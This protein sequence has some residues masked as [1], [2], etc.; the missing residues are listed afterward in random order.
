MIK[1][2]II[3]DSIHE[4]SKD[5]ITTFV[6]TFPRIILAELNTH[7]A[8][9]RNSASSR[10]I[11]FSKMVEAAE[12]T[13]FIPLKWMKDHPGMQ[14]TEYFNDQDAQILNDIWLSGR[15]HAVASAKLLRKGIGGVKVT[16][17]MCNR[18]LEPYMYH[19]AI[20]TATE[21]EN[22]FALRANDAA[23]IHIQELANQMLWAINE[24]QP[25]ILRPGDWHIPF[26]DLI[27]LPS[28]LPI[29]AGLT[30]DEGV[31]LAKVK[32][33]TARCAQV[34]YTLIGD[35]GKALDYWKLVALHNRLS[36]MGHWSPFEHCARA[37]NE[38]E[39][40]DYDHG[41]CGNFKGFKQYRK[42]FINENRTDSRLFRA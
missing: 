26:G 16:K 40:S 8:L 38:R 18:Q 1:A 7:R 42:F 33:A 39:Y 4:I 14:G 10:A 5:R 28:P 13:P 23:E 25:K 22:F 37:M 6:V 20:V 19:T 27:D 35:D 32:V 30:L 15:D 31:Q 11:P 34:S 41:W 24:S 36:S 3:A 9:S 12:K 21:F 2:D 17:Q 29:E